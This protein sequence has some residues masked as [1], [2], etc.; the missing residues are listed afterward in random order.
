MKY[1]LKVLII[2]LALQ[3]WIMSNISNK[4]SYLDEILSITLPI[5]IT[6]MILANKSKIKLY[7]SEII[8]FIS[9]ITFCI[10]TLM[11][12]YLYEYVDMKIAILSMILTVKSYIIYI[13]CRIFFN[14][15]K[16][17]INIL[18]EVTR[19]LEI[20]IYIFTII[21]IINIPI[22]FLQEGEV[23][24]GIIRCIKI[25]FSHYTEL[26][27]FAI[28]SL[29]VINFYNSLVNEKRN[30]KVI[31]LSCFILVILSGRSKAIGFIITYLLLDKITMKLKHFNMKYIIIAAPIILYV[32]FPRI[33]SEFI[34]GV[35]GILYKTSV[36]IANDHFLLGSGFGTFGSHISRV[37]YSTL[38]HTYNI[39]HVWGLSPEKSDFIS[40]TYWAMIIGESGWIGLALIVTALICIFFIFFKKRYYYETKKNVC[41]LI[42]YSMMASIAEPIYSSNKSVTIFLLLALFA[43]IITNNNYNIN[44]EYIK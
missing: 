36:S 25:G 16:I 5:I 17:D 34:D 41:A 24:F 2:V 38:Y 4:I 3:D 14:M 42:L 15:Y 30:L 21:G 18:K 40:D 11:G 20:T 7:K 22:H 9:I 31:N 1:I 8:A 28:V 29:V 37:H 19:I 43:Y 32:V 13:S 10:V 27:F 39:S 44:E 33:K 6:I 26:A 23:R 12:N 35:R